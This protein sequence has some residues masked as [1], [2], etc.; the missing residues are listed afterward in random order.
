[1]RFE[2]SAGQTLGLAEVADVH[3]CTAL[4][5]RW[6]DAPAAAG[7]AGFALVA[8]RPEGRGPV[9]IYL[10]GPGP[11]TATPLG[12]RDREKRGFHGRTYAQAELAELRGALTTQGLAASSPVLSSAHVFR[13][14]MWRTPGA[15][16]VLPVTVTERA[17]AAIARVEQETGGQ[18]LEICAS[19]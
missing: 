11:F 14:T 7:A 9:T 6:M 5:R 13:I 16:L 10:A 17:Q 8:S 18:G 12:W 2:K 4:E 15:P 1:V 3:A 19:R